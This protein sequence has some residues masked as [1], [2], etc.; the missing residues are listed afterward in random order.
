MNTANLKRYA[1]KARLDFIAAMQKQA[2]N[3][4]ITAKHIEPLEVKGDI[5]LIGGRTFPDRKSTRLNSSH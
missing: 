1:P 2:A 5:A 3:L 4:G